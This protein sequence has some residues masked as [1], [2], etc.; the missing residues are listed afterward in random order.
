MRI[1]LL[2]HRSA[3]SSQSQSLDTIYKVQTPPKAETAESGE[4]DH[5]F[6]RYS[7]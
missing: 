6:I 3:G 2:C 1:I 5:F 4:V 7:I